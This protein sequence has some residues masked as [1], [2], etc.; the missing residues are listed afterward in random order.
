[1]NKLGQR[2]HYQE[3]DFLLLADFEED[4]VFAQVDEWP[5]RVFWEM[6]AATVNTLTQP[7]KSEIAIVFFDVATELDRRDD[8]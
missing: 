6:L 8:R 7:L 3:S 2:T 5:L 1:M 4:T